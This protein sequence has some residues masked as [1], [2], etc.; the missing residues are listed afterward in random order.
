[1]GHGWGQGLKKWGARPGFATKTGDFSMGR[2][3]GRCH[4]A[5]GITEHVGKETSRVGYGPAELP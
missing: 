1:M 3:S 5:A 4:P 2:G